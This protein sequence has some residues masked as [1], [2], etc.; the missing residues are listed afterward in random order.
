MAGCF[1]SVSSLLMWRLA[2]RP[3]I[4]GMR[5]SMKDDVER[6]GAVLGLEGRDGFRAGRHHLHMAGKSA[7]RLCENLPRGCVV[8]HN[9]H[10]QLRELFRTNL[11]RTFGDTDF[12]PDGEEEGAANPGSLSSQTRPPISSTNRREMVRPSPVPPCLRVRGRVGLHE[13]LEEFRRLLPAS[14]RCPVSRTGE[15][16]LHL[17]ARAFEQLDVQPDLAV[18]RELHG[19][20]DKVRQDLAEA[21]RVAQQVLWNLGRDMREELQALVVRLLG[22]ERRD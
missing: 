6:L 11:P 9:Q 15:L 10:M 1:E 16:E 8:I 4:P 21:E 13:R 2:C 14:C 12:E 20:V 17:L 5:Q 18:L 19:V 3:S 7:E 22:G